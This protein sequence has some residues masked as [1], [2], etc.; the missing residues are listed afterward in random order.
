MGRHADP[1][2]RYSPSFHPR[3]AGLV[4]RTALRAVNS[5]TWNKKTNYLR[6]E[7]R[8]SVRSFATQRTDLLES[9]MSLVTFRACQITD[10][11]DKLKCVGL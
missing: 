5:T 1:Q 2:H 6:L 10:V 8:P 9:W 4:A 7:F 3:R 11:D